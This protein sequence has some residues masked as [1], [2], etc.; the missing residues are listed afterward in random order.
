[1]CLTQEKLQSLLL[2]DQ[3]TG[4]F[5]W[6]H[7]P[8]GKCKNKSVAGCV[9]SDG[10]VSI[11]IDGKYYKAHRLAWLYV[12]GY[13]PRQIDHRD[14]NKQNNKLSNLR[15]ADPM[16]NGANR[17]LFVSNKSGHKGVFW[18][19]KLKKW[20]ANLTVNNVVYYLGRF[21]SIEEAIAARTEAEKRHCVSDI[22]RTQEVA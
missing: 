5:K 16:I 7:P 15:A 13:F 14:R 6:L 20:Q 21:N 18:Y 11:G 17:G 9:K 19:A 22:H 8:N 12:H 2:Y 4:Q 1:M 3:E 10:Y